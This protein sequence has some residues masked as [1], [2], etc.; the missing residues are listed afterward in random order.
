MNE[1]SSNKNVYKNLAAFAMQN[2]DVINKMRDWIADCEWNDLPKDE[3]S[4]LDPVDIIKGVEANFD[5]GLEEFF[6]TDTELEKLVGG[7]TLRPTFNE[8]KKNIMTKSELKQ[9]IKESIAEITAERFN[10]Q[11]GDTKEE[12]LGFAMDS[13]E[14][15]VEWPLTEVMDIKEVNALLQPIRNRINEELKNLNI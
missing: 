4:E 14:R 8:S 2:P 9:L 11:W 5:G 13:L 6:K 7:A 3:I 12:V 10:S 15:H 1:G